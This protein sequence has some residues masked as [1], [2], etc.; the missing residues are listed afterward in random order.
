MGYIDRAYDE[1]SGDNQ[2]IGTIYETGKMT[3]Y[4]MEQAS[5]REEFHAFLRAYVN[6][7]K[8]KNASTEDFMAVLYG[9]L[10]RDNEK[11]NRILDAMFITKI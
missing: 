9:C 4:Q 6:K 1:F 8:F 11:L 10:G 3:L 2:Y 7:F 5:G